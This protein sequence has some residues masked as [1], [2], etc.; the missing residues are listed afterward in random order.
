MLLL[1]LAALGMPVYAQTLNELFPNP[2]GDDNNKEFVE[3]LLPQPMNLTGYIIGDEA[4]ND[5]LIMIQYRETNYSLIIEEGFNYSAINAS[6]YSVGATIGNDLGNTKDSLFLYNTKK[7][8]LDAMTYTVTTEGKSM[9]KNATG[10]FLSQAKNGTP[11]MEN[12][13]MNASGQN[14]AMQNTTTNETAKTMEKTITPEIN[15]VK[16]SFIGNT[17]LYLNQSYTKFFRV[18]NEQKERINV[19]LNITV[20]KNKSII[21]EQEQG[22]ENI[23]RYHTKGTS[24]LSFTE[25]GEYAICGTA[26]TGEKETNKIDNTICKTVTLL[27][28]ATIRCDRSLSILLNQSIYLNKKQIPL[29][30]EV[31][32]TVP[33][34]VPFKISYSIEEFSGKTAKEETNTTNLN[35]KHWTPDIKKEYAL[36][37]ISADLTNTGCQDTDED[38]NHATAQLIV[39]NLR[40]EDGT[41]EITHVYLGTDGVAK[42]GD[43]I[44]V[45]IMYYTG[46]LSKWAK[47]KQAIKIYVEDEKGNK[48]SEIT[49]LNL[50]E[51]Y[52]EMTLSVPVLMKYSCSSFP[53]VQEMYTVVAEG[54]G[55]K[56][57]KIPVQ[58]VKKELCNQ[59]ENGGEYGEVIFTET[60]QRTDSITTNFTVHNIDTKEHRYAISSKIY[61]GPKTYEGDFFVNQQKITLSPGEIQNL[62][63]ENNWSV[64]ESGTYSIKVQIQKDN[65]KTM[66]E[67]RST[68]MI[69]EEQEQTTREKEANINEVGSL[70][71]EP[72]EKALL[73]ADVQGNGNYTLQIDSVYEQTEIPL[74]LSGKQLVFFNASLAQGK[75]NIVVTLEQN[76]TKI[77]TMPLFLYATEEELTVLENQTSITPEMKKITGMTAMIPLKSYEASF[78]KTTTIINSG[79]I[80]LLLFFNIYLISKKHNIYKTTRAS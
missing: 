31:Q 75:N 40:E 34:E 37:T 27:D 21:L 61:R 53:T 73:F 36:Y 22:M 74:E 48:V 52:E 41:E 23:S 24:D 65:Y 60:A 49:T 47:E 33:E 45:K 62:S 13:N 17:T 55:T 10:W 68:I 25:A 46:N 44:S 11:G 63:L 28:P 67:F 4:S 6:I 38:N 66:K 20:W 3:I 16:I 59:A 1:I 29:K 8:L 7:L 69:G 76:K 79:L 30:F 43:I 14:T 72:K 42:Q 54:F 5:T 51:S 77:M 35:T 26:E 71:Q 12:S 56:K 78:T 80:L 2:E 70:T 50:E 58:G 57:Q 32:G 19:T 15:V 18:D 9:E 39:K 64:L